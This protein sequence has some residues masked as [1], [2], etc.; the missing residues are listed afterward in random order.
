MVLTFSAVMPSA[1]ARCIVPRCSSRSRP[2][3]RWEVAVV[4][5]DS[6]G[7]RVGEPSI[8]VR[9]A[10]GEPLVEEARLVEAGG[11]DIPL[12]RDLVGREIH[13]RIGSIQQIG[14][15]VGDDP[16]PTTINPEPPAAARRGGLRVR[17]HHILF[18]GREPM[19]IP[20][21]CDDTVRRSDIIR[22]LPME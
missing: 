19:P 7:E 11:K 4:A 22:V 18:A 5:I 1:I 3:S 14:R 6:K 21:F 12:T 10:T 16:I 2:I 9:T 20:S 13:N 17:P 15:V 8:V